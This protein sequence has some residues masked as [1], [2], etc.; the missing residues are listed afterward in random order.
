M[1]SPETTY[2]G[3][4]LPAGRPQQKAHWLRW[5]AI[6]LIGIPG[7]LLALYLTFIAHDQ[8]VSE[9]RFGL[10]A[11]TQTQASAASRE[12]HATLGGSEMTSE[13]FV[14][15]FAVV[16][17]VKSRQ[18]V[19]ELDKQLNLRGMWSKPAIDL[20]YRMSEDDTDEGLWR[21]WNRMVDIEFDMSTGAIIL[22]VRAFTP[23]DSL[24]LAQ[25][26]LGASEKL[27]NKMSVKAREDSVRFAQDEVQG[28]EKRLSEARVKV[29]D[30][31]ARTGVLDPVKE[32]EA[33]LQIAAKVR[34]DIATAA[35]ELDAMRAG[36]L[37][38]GPAYERVQA[39]YQALQR[40]LKELND[41]QISV[42]RGAKPDERGSLSAVLREY[43]SAETERQFAEVY[44]TGALKA[45]EDA[46]GMAARQL[47]YTVVASQPT[48][49]D[50][51]QYPRRMVD[52]ALGVLGLFILW[53]VAVLVVYAIKDH[54]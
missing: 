37:R 38:S 11:G 40:Q 1:T 5:S 43:E 14:D 41:H 33:N 24:R 13:L 54:A 21:Q 7:V 44:Y 51:S 48:M 15:S 3:P 28:A 27:V 25:A 34:G 22:R 8:Y 42:A 4:R 26:I 47:L 23:E 2:T 36:G 18:I 29:Q 17:Y 9:A 32:A 52:T 12:G 31:R 46:R 6:L 39:R 49:A 35:A 50:E 19:R 45:L 20:W 16:D 53:I 30:L 10:R